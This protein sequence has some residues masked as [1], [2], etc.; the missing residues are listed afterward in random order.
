MRNQIEIK[1]IKGVTKISDQIREARLRWYGHVVRKEQTE[2]IKRAWREPVVGKRS[3]GRQMLKWRD[4]IMGGG[5][6]KKFCGQALTKI[7][8]IV[9][10]RLR[11]IILNVRA[12]QA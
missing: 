12:Y 8:D 5:T 3:R 6:K 9:A 1:S 4:I 2:D 11:I 7:S 10:C